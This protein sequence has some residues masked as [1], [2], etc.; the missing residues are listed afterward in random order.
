MILAEKS[1]AMPRKQ[2]LL[3]FILGLISPRHAQGFRKSRKDAP[4]KT[5]WW[6]TSPGYL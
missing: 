5:N 3:G 4:V 2:G 1:G 6:P